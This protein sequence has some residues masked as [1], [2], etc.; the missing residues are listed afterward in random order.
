VIVKSGG[1]RWRLHHLFIA[2]RAFLFLLLRLLLRLTPASMPSELNFQ[3]A[4][5][6]RERESRVH[7][8]MADEI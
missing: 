2:A 6:Y 3:R 8:R 4:Q 1:V 7:A 5:R